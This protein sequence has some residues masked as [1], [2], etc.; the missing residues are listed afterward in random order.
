MRKK[1]DYTNAVFG[2]LTVI[3][4]NKELKKWKCKCECGNFKYVRAG[5]LKRTDKGAV[6][7]CG[8]LHKQRMRETRTPDITNQVF[9][10]LKV[11]GFAE[12]RGICT[13]WNCLCECGREKVI[14]YGHLASGQIRSCGCL[15]RQ[16]HTKHGKSRDKDYAMFLRNSDPCRHLKYLIS[17]AI[18]DA[19]KKQNCNK[20]GNKTFDFLPYSPQ[21]L[22]EHLESLWEP[23]MNW[24]NY[25]GLMNDTRMTW[26]IDHIIPQSNFYYTSMLDEGFQKCWALE[27][28][29]PLEKHENRAKGY[30]YEKTD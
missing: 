21:Q 13:Y 20:N 5:E 12:R 25:G 22:K 19:L 23:W 4:Y 1:V 6:R 24:E 27:N 9:G 18:R 17:G 7:S 14:R 3:E 15:A 2:R 16:V 10:K 11:I 29:R 26:H 30:Q 28:L 8:C